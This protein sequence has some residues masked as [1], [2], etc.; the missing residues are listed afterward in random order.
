MICSQQINVRILTPQKTEKEISIFFAVQNKEYGFELDSAFKH[1]Q[2]SL[3]VQGE[4]SLQP[5]NWQISMKVKYIIKYK[6]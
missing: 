3:A 6:L 2:H 1:G 5:N 4:V